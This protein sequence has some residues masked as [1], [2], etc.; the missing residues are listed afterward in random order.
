MTTPTQRGSVLTAQDAGS[1][2]WFGQS[3]TLSADGSVL[4]VGASSWE[5]T[6]AAQGG[7]YT[8][9]WS[10]TAWVQ[11]G[12]VLTAQDAA[13]SDNFGIS[14]ALSADGSVLAVGAYL[15]E[16]TATSQGGVYIYDWSG[17]AWVQR[18]SV[19][20]AQDA[21][22][23]DYFGVSCTLSADGSVL[24]VGAF[25]WE[26]T[27]ADQGGVYI[28][29]WSGTAW[30]QRGA[31][32]TAADAAASD[33]FGRS[34]ALS[35]DGSVLAV[36][37]HFWEGTASDQGGV[38]IYDW[39]GTAWVQ[40]G[41]VLTAAD[42]AASDRFGVSCALSADGSVLAVGASSWEG[43]AADQGGV[44]IYDW[45]GT[46]WVQRGAVLTAADAAADDNFGVS[47][48]LSADGSVLAVGAHFW[49]GTASDQGGVYIYDW[50]LRSISGVVTDDTGA[51]C[52]RTVRLYNRVNGLFMAT[53]TS[54]PTTGAFAFSLPPGVAEVQRVVLDDADG[55]LYNDLIDRVIPG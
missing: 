29:D 7:V 24:A 34:C 16:G 37:A 44:Y 32:L 46:A 31:V 18:G 49:E 23:S 54:D 50:S 22:A 39:S 45:S 4:A 28:Y 11:R 48:A 43:T 27:A 55:T 40:R 52:Q 9:D 12:S 13:A 41:A 25:G 8:Y 47:C 51:P 6:A 53:T 38:Y 10:V 30:V 36:G 17:T 21:A 26:G 1:G 14:C 2:D 35:A 42:A 33:Y 5:G 15:W 3:C 19:L 20:T